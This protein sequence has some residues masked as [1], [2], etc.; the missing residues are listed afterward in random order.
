MEKQEIGVV[1]G[2]KIYRIIEKIDSI[3]T[4]S[5]SLDKWLEETSIPFLMKL[6]HG[7]Y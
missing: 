7:I 3:F 2:Y 4:V 5:Y 1:V 6:N